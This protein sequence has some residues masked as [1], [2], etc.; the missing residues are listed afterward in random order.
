MG[1]NTKDNGN[2]EVHPVG[3]KGQL[4]TL[5]SMADS[6]NFPLFAS[7]DSMQKAYDE[8]M[9]AT[10]TFTSEDKAAAIIYLH[11]LLNSIGATIHNIVDPIDPIK[12]E[13]DSAN[14]TK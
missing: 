6:L 10:D 14:G 5:T 11:V 8:F 13:G 4:E 12:L 9:V 1:T 7:K 3:T 2:F